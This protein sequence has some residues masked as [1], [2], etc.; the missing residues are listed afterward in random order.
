MF[1]IHIP[2]QYVGD[3]NE[4]RAR[5]I[6]S[7]EAHVSRVENVALAAAIFLGAA[8]PSAREQ[9]KSLADSWVEVQ[10][11]QLIERIEEM[12]AAPV[13]P[14]SEFEYGGA[15]PERLVTL[16]SQR[17]RIDQQ[18]ATMEGGLEK[19]AELAPGL[20]SMFRGFI[21]PMLESQRDSLD[22]QIALMQQMLDGQATKGEPT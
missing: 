6:I 17:E 4:Q 16:Q 21:M 20:D 19:L 3:P 12:K 7:M 11:A 15:T 9:A 2:P 14:A 5:D 8:F 18:I 10:T 13:I 22:S 1:P